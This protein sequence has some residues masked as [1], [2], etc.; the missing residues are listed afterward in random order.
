MRI[1]VFGAGIAG[2]TVAHELSRLGHQVTVYE[3]TGEVGGFFRSA[4]RPEDAGMPSEYSWHGFGPWYSNAFAVLRQIPFDARGSVYDR[5]LSRPVKFGVAPDS[6]G[7][8]EPHNEDIGLGSG[9]DVFVNSK[10]FRM[11]GL[12]K[13]GRAYLMLK[14]WAANLRSREVYALENAAEAWRPFM[15]TRALKIWRSTFGP[16]VGSDWVRVNLHTVGKFFQKNFLSGPTHTHREDEHGPAWTHGPQDGWLLLSRPSSEAWFDPWVAELRARGVRFEFN[17]PLEGLSLKAHSGSEDVR[18]VR[19]AVVRSSGSSVAVLADH[20]VMATTPFAAKNVLERSDPEFVPLWL[21]HFALTQDGPHTQVSFRVAFSEKIRWPRER[22]AVVLSDSEW[23]ITLFD[24]EQIFPE[25]TL[26]ENVRSL[27]TGTACVSTMPGRVHGLP[28]GNCTRQQFEE[29]ILEQIKDCGSLDALLRE[30]NDGRGI[31][32]FERVRFEVWSEWAFSPAGIEPL[33]PKWVNSTTT[34]PFLPAQDSGFAN[35]SL[36]GAHT[37]TT[38][39]VWSIEAA[40]E[41]GRLAARR[42]D[43]RVPVIEQHRS[44]WLRAVQAMDD[45]LYKVGGPNVVDVVL[46]LVCFLAV[47]LIGAVMR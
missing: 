41:S 12:D 22:C 27:W 7:A 19:G 29:E 23:N 11:T 46:A 6:P 40:V 43:A 2:L 38:A 21:E 4:R 3:A 44:W 13:L 37:R 8:P 20:Y 9:R 26:G 31:L 24:Q 16:W 32:D 5:C 39:D 30:S 1:A 42:V 10:M 47:L 17:A 33:Q 15:S 34:Q 28:L 36:A 35:L 18:S 45:G 14:T 25:G